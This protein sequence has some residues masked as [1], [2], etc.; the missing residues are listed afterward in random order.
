MVGVST[1]K[2]GPILG[3]DCSFV[4]IHSI[5][6]KNWEIFWSLPSYLSNTAA[7]T[8]GHREGCTMTPGPISDGGT[9]LK[10]GG[11]KSIQFFHLQ[12]TT[13]SYKLT[14]IFV[15]LAL[16]TANAACR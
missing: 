15:V 8:Q 16:A 1:P 14:A 11:P 13:R 12:R 7:L 3:K 6:V 5:S 10:V 2:I 4:F 9:I